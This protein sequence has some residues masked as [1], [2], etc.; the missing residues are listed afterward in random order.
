MVVGGGGA[1]DGFRAMKSEHSEVA[2]SG[3]LPEGTDGIPNSSR[4]SYRFLECKH[5]TVSAST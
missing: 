2:A 1:F 3:I 4:H 5:P